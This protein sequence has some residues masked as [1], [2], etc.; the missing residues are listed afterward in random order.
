MAILATA[1]N[2]GK[3]FSARPLFEGVCFTLAE[4]ERVGLIGPNGAGKTTLLRILAGADSPDQGELVLRRGLRV[5]HV[6]QVPEFRP[7]QS[8]RQAVLEPAAGLVDAE[9]RW[10]TEARA[11]E[12]CA[13]LELSG[14]QAGADAP[15]DRL[16]GGWRK[17]VALAR[18]LLREPELL[19]LDEPTNHLDVESI[20]WLEDFLAHA[21]FATVTVTHDRLFLQRVSHRILELDRRNAG[22]LLSVDGD[23]ATFLERKADLM[24]AQERREASL[25]NTLRRETEWLRRG[26]PARSTKQQAR[27][28]RVLALAGTVDELAARNT[29]GTA[30]LDFGG[31]GRQPKRLLEAKAIAKTYGGT[32]IFRG[33]D[34]FLGP[35]SRVGLIGKNGCG[36]STLLRVLVGQESPDAGTVIRADNLQVAYFEQQRESLDPAVTVIDTLCPGGDQVDFRGT[37]VHVNGYLAR[38]LFRPEQAKLTVGQLSGGEQS[39]LALAR[40]MLRPANVLVLDEPTNDLDLATLDVLEETLTNFDGAV[41]LVSHDRYFLDRAT[42]SLLAFSALPGGQVTHLVGLS[43]WEAWYAAEREDL[44]AAAERD[45]PAVARAPASGPRRKL[46]YLDQREFDTIE[47]RIADAEARLAALEAEQ[48]RPELASNASRLVEL[49]GQIEGARAEIDVLFARWSEL[50]AMLAEG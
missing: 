3:S 49:I 14:P 1:R 13:R 22:G 39:R 18:E 33:I 4:G 6:A 50:E 38:F 36:K 23:Y 48:A 2:L 40:L 32:T 16:S 21:P 15:V 25:R 27:I 8:V 45:R 24:A 43:Q 37:W 30:A 17:R 28:Q 12:L 11:D 29:V 35:G 7:G 42:T 44:A 20:L 47:A 26:A 9:H 10:Q 5:G 41:L 46:S 31:A 19:L 34:L